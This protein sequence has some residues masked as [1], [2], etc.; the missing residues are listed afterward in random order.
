LEQDGREEHHG[1]IYTAK[2]NAIIPWA[3]IQRPPHWTG[4]DPNPGA[5]F[6]V[7]EDG[8]YEVRRGY[9]MYKQVSR[10]GQPG[11][12]VARTRAHD[13][14]IAII[15]FASNQTDNPD[16]FVVVNIGKA[17]KVNVHVKGTAA[18]VFRAFRTTEDE[19]DLYRELGEYAV[20]DGAIVYDA[21][22][23]SVTTF[24]AVPWTAV[25]LP[26]NRECRSRA[27][28]SSSSFRRS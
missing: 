11:M 5:A 13:S 1:N 16:A 22:T 27:R 10:A 15:G 7:R 18:D 6:T 2:V 28:P 26:M 23:G 9:Y 21:P 19:K 20:E 24:F 8:T 12:A 4:G 17:R 3:G 14:E 25:Y